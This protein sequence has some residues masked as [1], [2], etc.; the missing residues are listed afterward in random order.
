MWAEEGLASFYR[1]LTPS[2]IGILPY[3]GV[4]IC[5]FEMLKEHL[6]EV[7][8]DQPPHMYILGT[9]MLS[10]SVAQVVSYPLALIRTRLQAQGGSGCPIKYT[11]MAD[12]ARQTVQREGV[13]G[14]YKGLLANLV[15]LAPAAGISWYI[16]E[17]T[18]LLLGVDPRS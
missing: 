7:Y 13:R 14:L 11:G 18:K 1:G 17:E 6:L 15:K 10:S 2:M 16:F 9:G 5:V 8:D 4:D 12:V 3:A